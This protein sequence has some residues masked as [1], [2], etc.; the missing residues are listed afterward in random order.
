MPTGFIVTHRV[1]FSETDMA[2]IMHFS[3]FFRLMEEVEH[4]FFRSIGMSVVMQHDGMHI[5]WPRV[6]A[7]CEYTGPVK[8]EQEL[9]LNMRVVRVGN[10]SFSYEVDFLLEGKPIALGKITS[11]CCLLEQ[12][13]MRSIAIPAALR[14]KLN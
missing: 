5:G 2:G 8:F 4:A 13:A 9:Q 14:D 11:V 1:Q 3:N 10:K 7:S 6:S 12:G